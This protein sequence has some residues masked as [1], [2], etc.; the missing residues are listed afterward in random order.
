MFGQG[1]SVVLSF[2]DG[3]AP[4]DAL[5]TILN[6]LKL[7]RIVAEFYVLGEEVRRHPDGRRGPSLVRTRE[8][9]MRN[10]FI[11]GIAACFLLVGC[12]LPALDQAGR[13]YRANRDY[14]SLETIYGQLTEGMARADVEGFLGEPDY[15][16]IDGQ[17]YYS[18]D[19]RGAADGRDNVPVGVV[20]DYRE[21]SGAVT[22]TLQDFWIGPIGE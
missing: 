21:E 8:E 1:K 18:S 19:R 3:P 20:V 14:A 12:G 15:S 5:Q 7:N 2:D 22:D 9:M 4:V 16:P 17:F 6:T 10:L 13:S 11:Y